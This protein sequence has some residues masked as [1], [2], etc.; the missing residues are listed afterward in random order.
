MVI[1]TVLSLLDM[2]GGTALIFRIGGLFA[3]IFGIFHLSKGI[4][5]L[6]SSFVNRFWFD[7]MGII[8][9]ISGIL[10]FLFYDNI[11]VISSFGFATL[12]KGAYSLATSSI[13][14]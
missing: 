12:A 5:S 1:L 8:D 3:M 7:W 2:L 6:G 14:L 11:Y 13:S 10:L 9:L 4:F